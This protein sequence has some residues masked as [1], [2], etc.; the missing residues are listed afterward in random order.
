MVNRC[1]EQNL[2][3]VMHVLLE[4]AIRPP[5]FPFRVELNLFFYVFNLTLC[6]SY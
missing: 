6:C 3:Y 4:G 1:C 5:F 2:A